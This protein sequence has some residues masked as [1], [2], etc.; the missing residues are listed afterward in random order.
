MYK[1]IFIDIDGTLRDSKRNLS[2]KTKETIKKVTD[3]GILVILCSGRPR[4]YTEDLSKKCGA[5]RYIINS[6]GSSIYD[7]EEQKVLYREIMDKN[8]C[9]DLYEIAEKAGVRFMMDVGDGR[10]VT[11][12]KQTD[13]SETLLN[14]DID[15][16]LRENDVVQCIV[17]DE[18]FEKIKKLKNKVE[19]VKNAEV[20]NRHKSLTN[21]DYPKEGTIYYDLAN[22]ECSK[23]NAIKKFCEKMNIELKDTIA[24]GDGLND[25]SMFEV[26]G[27]SVA[28]GNSPEKVK[29]KASEVTLSN[30]QDGVAVFLEKLIK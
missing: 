27:Y 16:F 1:A 23:G 28:M 29:E 24:I 10:V 17:A 6:G 3:K 18:D 19:S 11:K 13:G 2:Q 15:T 25:I 5:S 4:K 30:D 12:I 7:Y 20:K 26:A 9:K 8:A 22:I 14:T 21:K